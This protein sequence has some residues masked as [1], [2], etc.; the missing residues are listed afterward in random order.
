[1]R[2]SALLLAFLSTTALTPTDAEAGP[3]AGFIAAA[4][5][6]VSAAAT[7]VATAVGG[8]FGTAGVFGA[9]GPAIGQIVLSVG[10]SAIAT[11]L[12]PRPEVPKPS[13]R[14][15][16][17]AQPITY[18]E[19]VYGIVRK[20]GPIAFTVFQ[21]ARLYAVILAA[22][23]IDAIVEHWLDER[24]V[25]VEGTTVT[26]DPPGDRV[27]IETRLGRPGQTAVQSIVAAVPEWTNAHDMAG[28]AYGF[29]AASPVDPEKF[30]KTYPSGREPAWSPVIRGNNQ[31]Y[32]PRTGTYGFSRNW[33]LC[34][35]H[36][37]TAYQGRKVDWNQI[38]TE[39]SISDSLVI[40]AQGQRQARWTLDGVVSDDLEWEDVRA[41]M[42]AAGDGFIYERPDG[43]V[44]IKAGLWR[45]PTVT[46]TEADFITLE[47]SEGEDMGA[48]TE[49]V[50]QYVEP[51][52]NY[53]E[54]PSGAWVHDPSAR[55]VR[56][57]VAAFMVSSHHQATR[58]A[59]RVARA[60]RAKYRLN[61]TLKLSGYDLIGERFA[62]FSHSELDMTFPIEIGKLVWNADRITFN[63]E[64]VS[65]AP[66]D[67]NFIAG[68]EEPNRPAYGT[69]IS[70]STIP[71][72]TG[73]Q[74][75][76]IQSTGGSAA[77]E[78]RWTAQSAAYRQQL[79]YRATN[80][81]D[82]QYV[83]SSVGGQTSVIVTGLV[84]GTIYEAQIR[85]RTGGG[86]ASEWKPD[87]TTQVLAVANQTPPGS[88]SNFAAAGAA[89]Q[90]TITFDAPNDQQYYATR[91]YRSASVVFADAELVRTEYGIPSNS[92]SWTETG[93]SAGTWN[94]WGEPI[95][96]SGI[97]GS[98]SGPDA[99]TV[100]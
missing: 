92:D 1:M 19:R 41:Q 13:A 31:I 94:Y 58:L 32:D 7:S 16:N 29:V 57:E 72:V 49:F 34:V 24:R 68:L 48:P 2:R 11:L 73:F 69:P 66:Q 93:L 28:L 22:H 51:G 26:T 87:A 71:N 74:G 85:N 35:A 55:R 84:D 95:N 42:M 65:T 4:A 3:V 61:G 62:Q 30:S 25:S 60:R 79:R 50:V 10:L 37:L 52:N 9:F 75:S 33:A 53:R 14:M 89:G 5:S 21:G 67:F 99:A 23:P 6:A 100:T 18:M 70:V 15:V 88:L 46:L 78:W 39:A 44:G 17:Y 63:L 8:V 64:A 76:A 98:I 36:E 96:A 40:N 54:S 86:S 82:W 77:I 27:G 90:A 20:G 81:V 47:I 80:V 83:I 56:E 43:R 38:A 45:E 91:I 12:Q 59:K 97:G